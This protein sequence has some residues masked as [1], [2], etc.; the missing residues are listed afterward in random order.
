MICWVSIVT[1]YYD[2]GCLGGIGGAIMLMF[3]NMFFLSP[4][5]KWSG[6]GAYADFGLGS[7]TQN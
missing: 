3:L 5:E 2:T 4:G 6:D 1:G 7:L